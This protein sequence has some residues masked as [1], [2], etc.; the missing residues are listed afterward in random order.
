M[1]QA[2]QLYGI[3]HGTTDHEDW[4]RGDIQDRAGDKKRYMHA[5]TRRDPRACVVFVV[6]A[7]L[8]T[9]NHHHDSTTSA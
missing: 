1:L 7:F 5:K 4:T 3:K 2:W 8:G 9:E 6:M